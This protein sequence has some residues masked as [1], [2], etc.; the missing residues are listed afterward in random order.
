MSRVFPSLLGVV[1]VLAAPSAPAAPDPPAQSDD[2]ELHVVCVREGIT[3]TGD[4]IHGGKAA[5]RVDRPG[6]LVTLV[7]C[8]SDT[9]TWD[10]SL[11]PQTR[12]AKVVLGGSQKQAVRELPPQVETIIAF[13]DGPE[14]MVGQPTVSGADRIDSVLFRRMV[15]EVYELTRQEIVSFQGARQPAPGQLFLVDRVQADPR[16]RSDYPRP[17][18]AAELPKLAFR[19]VEFAPGRTPIQT[20]AFFRDYTLA[21]PVEATRQPLPRGV[22]RLAVDP[23]TKKTYGLT[24]QEV[25]EVDLANGRAAPMDPGLDVPRMEL[26]RGITFDT[27]RNQLL[28]AARHLY[29]Y[30]PTTG[31]WSVR[32]ELKDLRPAA[33]AYHPGEDALFALGHSLD[34]ANDRG[35]LVLC[36]YD[37]TGA[38][39]GKTQLGEPLF[40][41]VVSRFSPGNHTQLVA[42]GDFLVVLATQA[43]PLSRPRDFETYLFLVEPKTGKVQLTWRSHER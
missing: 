35:A 23:A 40:P 34:F 18:P 21:G 22:Q 32:A 5:V 30:D 4:Q 10:V 11:T 8:A 31:K 17:V 13:R 29:T 12:L 26:A 43:I 36:R 33:L 16:L 3:K 2:R 15:R 39:V 19:A 37:D 7:L 20:A 41:S 38:R 42:A 25:V 1:A 27:K 14:L 6:K 9:V 28:V 24:S